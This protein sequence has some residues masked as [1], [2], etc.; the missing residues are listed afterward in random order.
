MSKTDFEMDMVFRLRWFQEELV[1]TARELENAPK[2][3]VFYPNGDPVKFYSGKKLNQSQVYGITVNQ[4]FRILGDDGEIA[5]HYNVPPYE[6]MC[7]A[8]KHDCQY[9]SG[10]KSFYKEYEDATAFQAFQKLCLVLVDVA[11]FWD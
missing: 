11:G 9:D 6:L 4:Y 7:I 10:T 2:I 8:K 1:R 3:P 5:R